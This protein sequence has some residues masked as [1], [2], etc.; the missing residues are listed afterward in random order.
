MTEQPWQW[1]EKTWRGHVEHVRAGRPLRPASWPGG[2]KVAVALSFDSDHETPALRDGDVL[3][4]KMAQGEYGARV[5]VPRLLKLLDRHRA[6]ASFFVPAVSALLH[7]GEVK[8]YVDAG[9]EV[10]LHGW[11]HERNTALSETEERDLAFRAADVLERLAGTRPVG[12]RT[13]SWDFSAHTLAITR[14]LGLKYDSSLMADDDCYELLEHGEPTGVVELPVEWIRD[15]APYFM[16]DRFA[17]LRPYTPPR[18]V[19]SIWRDEFDAAHAEGGIFQLTMHPHIIG[20]R[21]RITVLSELLD[22][23]TSHDDVWFA[24]HAQIVDHVLQEQP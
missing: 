3:P 18:G 22:H 21:S 14:E 20:H 13:P 11:I 23:I 8:S 24:T 19:L 17:S 7:D 1:D 12:I 2:A 6:P 5:G 10:A 16:M 15:D 4:G 9:H